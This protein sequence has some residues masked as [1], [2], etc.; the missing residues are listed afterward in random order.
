MSS[1]ASSDTSSK[2]QALSPI[3]TQTL[4]ALMQAVAIPSYRALATKAGISRWQIQQI[5][6]GN[7]SNMRLETL[8][9]LSN[10]LEIPLA[11]LLN[12]F[13]PDSAA[14]PADKTP[15]PT[16]P[17]S[18]KPFIRLTTSFQL[19]TQN[20]HMVCQTNM[21]KRGLESR[22]IRNRF[23][24]DTWIFGFISAFAQH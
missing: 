13:L 17:P 19:P 24:S 10:A 5:R 20:P 2:K 12:H 11:T 15:Q 6:T 9:K 23:T 3:H 4:Q 16:Q 8:S 22:I 1:I 18:P 21:Q 14:T 7:I